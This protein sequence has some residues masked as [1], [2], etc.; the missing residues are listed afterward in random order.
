MVRVSKDIWIKA[1]LDKIFD[2]ICYPGNLPEIWPSLKQVSD[3]AP[4]PNGGYSLHWTYAMLGMYFEGKAEY[5]E[6]VPNEYCVCET[7]GGIKSIII[8]TV[9][10][11]QN[12]TRVT[13]TVEYK[14]PI[15]LLGKLAEAII[16]KA[17]DRE[18]NLIMANLKSRME[19]ENKV[20]AGIE[21]A[22]KNL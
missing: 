17:N 3:L 19:A 20:A 18:G 22:T 6:V 14:V 12:K 9:R 8:W 5:T 15:P 11:W 2:F 1:S 4:L 21:P 10:S 13:F 7:R 16:V